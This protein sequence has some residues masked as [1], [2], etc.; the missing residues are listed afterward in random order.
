M[1]NNITKGL[2]FIVLGIAVSSGCFVFSILFLFLFPPLGI[3]GLVFSGVW[4]I[5]SIIIGIVMM[6]KS[7]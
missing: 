7:H 6:F 3:L 4:I 2:T 5:L 1:N